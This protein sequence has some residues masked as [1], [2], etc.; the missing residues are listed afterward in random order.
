MEPYYVEYIDDWRGERVYTHDDPGVQVLDPGVAL[1]AVDVLKGVLVNGT[2]RRYPLNVP[3]AGKTGHAG[4]QHQRLV[5]RV[6]AAADDSRV[7][8]RPRRLHTDG[9]RARDSIRS[10]SR[11]ACTRRRSG[12][13]T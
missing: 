10:A 2:G 4:Q 9:Q 11:V 7:G 5:R 12:S 13:S 8:R 1:Q 3:A 6:H